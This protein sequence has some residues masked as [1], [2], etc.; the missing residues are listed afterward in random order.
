MVKLFN[1]CG[2]ETLK[3]FKE[4]KGFDVK[5]RKYTDLDKTKPFELKQQI[6]F[7]VVIESYFNRNFRFYAHK[8]T[9]ERC[10][11]LN[12]LEELAVIVYNDH[13]DKISAMKFPEDEDFS[14]DIEKIQK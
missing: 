8:E 1:K 13:S 10:Q 3:H 6:Q 4:E 5:F 7:C 11:K 12:P 2:R 14:N 9:F